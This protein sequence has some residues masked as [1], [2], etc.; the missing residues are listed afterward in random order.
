MLLF[1]A[2]LLP[3]LIDLALF[4][5]LDKYE[6]EPWGLFLAAFLYG[7]IP[8]VIMAIIVELA[9][10]GGQFFAM[11]IVAPIVEEL[12]KGFAVLLVFLIWRREFDG[13]LDG[14]LYGAVVGLGF[15]MVENFFYFLQGA[16][17]GG[18]LVLILLRA[19]AF[20]LNHAFFTAF[21]GASLGLARQSRWRG[22]W[23]L[24]FPLGLAIATTFHAI[25]NASVSSEACAGL[26][27]AFV[28][29]YVGLI[30]ILVF[31]LLTWRQEKRWIREE[32]SEEV[33]A[34]LLAPS[35][36]EALLS[37]RR[38]VWARIWTWRKRGWKYYRLLGRYMA[39]STELAFRKHHLRR[40]TTDKRL[41][42]DV[43]RLRQQVNELRV[44]LSGQPG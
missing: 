34:G 44:A 35:D 29:D 12:V 22:A 24:Y 19:L 26:G 5:W 14:I 42:A 32:L 2:A 4:W 33:A 20:G 17:E 37:L 13:I 31:G 39:A 9:I 8:A 3:T 40:D 36:M 11:A 21:T 30:L 28:S 7:C 16:E 43:Q 10:G 1:L 25:H 15:A 41:I 23:V 18:V 6:K 27:I 38:R